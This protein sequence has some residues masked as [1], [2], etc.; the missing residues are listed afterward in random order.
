MLVVLRVLEREKGDDEYMEKSLVVILLM[1]ANG[2]AQVWGFV[3]F[4]RQVFLTPQEQFLL[5]PRCANTKRDKSV[6]SVASVQFE[7]ER[8]T[9][10]HNHQPNHHRS[11]PT[12]IR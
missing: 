9:S 10:M 2:D 11:I 8:C 7:N 6:I 12:Y 1:T 4:N 3:C 5:D